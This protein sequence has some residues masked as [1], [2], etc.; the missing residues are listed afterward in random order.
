MVPNLPQLL[1][2]A[3]ASGTTPPTPPPAMIQPEAQ[4]NMAVM[5]ANFLFHMMQNSNNNSNNNTSAF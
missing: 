3:A 1:Q 4:W 2:L 5:V